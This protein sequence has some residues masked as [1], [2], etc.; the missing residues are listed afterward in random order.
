MGNWSSTLSSQGR[1]NA[2]SAMALESTT[3]MLSESVSPH[4]N[5]ELAGDPDQDPIEKENE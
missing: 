5:T 3:S 4:A 1:T 2:V